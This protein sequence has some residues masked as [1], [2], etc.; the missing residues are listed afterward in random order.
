MVVQA[1]Y[2]AATGMCAMETKLDVVANNLANLETTAFKGAR[3]NFEDLFYRQ[4]K[5]PGAEDT[6]GQYT[7]TGVAIGMG[8]R[9]QSTQTNFTQG[10]FRET[11]RELD[12][13]IE[14]RGFFQVMNPDGTTLYTRAG[15]LSINSNGDLVIGSAS[16]GRL[17]EPP[18]NIPEDT[19]K[20]VVSPEGIVSVQ[21][22]SNNNLSQIGQIELATF[23]N[24]EGLIKLGENMF[25]ESDAS[26]APLLGNPGQDQMGTIQQNMLEASNV[27]PVQEII[28]LIT[29]Q[30]AFEM[31]SQAIKV[32]D[33]IMQNIANLRRY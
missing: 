14:G 13:A 25:A 32:G 11:G 26:G 2:S 6:A 18:L 20:I 1:L 10:A 30:R 4:E 23:I 9:T 3:A 17:L 19:L 33:E 15:N 27:E 22:P 16:T 29:T 31:N 8:V 21:Q 28:D 7:P 12:L 24:P 5:L